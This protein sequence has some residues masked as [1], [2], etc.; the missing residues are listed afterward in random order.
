MIGK[1]DKIIGQLDFYNAFSADVYI[2][3]ISV[4][5]IFYG[6]G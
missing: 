2:F 5:N 1:D 6:C 4:W 3:R